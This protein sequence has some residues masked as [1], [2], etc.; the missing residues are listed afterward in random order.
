MSKLLLCT[1]GST[2]Y[3]CTVRDPRRDL[4]VVVVA[5]GARRLRV[6][7]AGGQLRR[8]DAQLVEVVVGRVRQDARGAVDHL[9]RV[10]RAQQLDGR[11]H[12][13]VEPAV[14]AL[15]RRLVQPD[16]EQV[17]HKLT[18]RDPHDV[19]GL[20]RRQLLPHEALEQLLKLVEDP[21][22]VKVACAARRAR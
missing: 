9:P 8:A 3:W 7:V 11:V 14:D 6:D 22:E 4:R 2:L 1:L 12:H 10:M 17:L 18:E 20:L 15:R 5:A 16:L 19:R 13:R 21:V